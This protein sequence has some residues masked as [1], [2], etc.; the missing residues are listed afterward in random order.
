MKAKGDRSYNAATSACLAIVVLAGMGT[1]YLP[2]YKVEFGIIASVAA[3]VSVAF[4]LAQRWGDVDDASGRDG[5]EMP[6]SA[7][8]QATST[9]QPVLREQR[10]AA[11]EIAH[12]TNPPDDDLLHYVSRWLTERSKSPQE[13]ALDKLVHE[14]ASVWLIGGADWPSKFLYRDDYARHVL[15]ARYIH[16]RGEAQRQA[17]LYR[18]ALDALVREI[19][20]PATDRAVT[21]DVGGVKIVVEGATNVD[22]R[23]QPK[24]DR[25]REEGTV[26]ADRVTKEGAANTA[27]KTTSDNALTAT[28]PEGTQSPRHGK[29]SGKTEE[30]PQYL[31]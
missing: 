21:I 13:S 26:P 4:Y 17:Q 25:V 8:A 29:I 30:R 5:R 28:V 3:A 18:S 7:A 6:R 9:S 24:I 20:R 12:F 19:L 31:N 14:T 10:K 11:R 22:I 1:S 23:P 27:R 2:E 15:H 16:E